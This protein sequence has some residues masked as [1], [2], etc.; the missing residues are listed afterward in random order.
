MKLIWMHKIIKYLASTK[1][2]SS[3]FEIIIG[4]SY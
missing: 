3:L 2:I 4:K 1:Y